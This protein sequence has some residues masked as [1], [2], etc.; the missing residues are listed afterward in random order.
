[1]HARDR[2][3]QMDIRRRQANGTLAELGG[4]FFLLSDQETHTVN[5]VPFLGDIPVLG[6]L[7]RGEQTSK[8]KNN[9][10]IFI[11]PQIIRDAS[12]MKEIVVNEL[13]NRKDR[14]ESELLE[15]YGDEELEGGDIAMPRQLPR[16]VGLIVTRSAPVVRSMIRNAVPVHSRA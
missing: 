2:F 12:Q 10:I 14:I 5:K 6:Y 7:F 16:T 1:M 15:I 9:L 4:L 11:T 13:R 8:S 3:F